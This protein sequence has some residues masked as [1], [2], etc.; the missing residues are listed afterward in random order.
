MTGTILMQA[1]SLRRYLPAWNL[2]I[3]KYLLASYAYL[4]KVKT[5]GLEMHQ[6]RQCTFALSGLASNDKAVPLT[7]DIV[8]R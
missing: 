4:Y 5:S 2:L 1:S 8:Y 3:K 7:C 6:A